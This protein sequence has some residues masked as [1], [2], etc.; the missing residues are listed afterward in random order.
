MDKKVTRIVAEDIHYTR[1]ELV[2]P[3]LAFAVVFMTN[4]PIEG[5]AHAVDPREQIYAITD[6]TIHRRDDNG[7][8][9]IYFDKCSM[10]DA[11]HWGDEKWFFD[12]ITPDTD[13]FE[14]RVFARME[15]YLNQ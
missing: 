3:D 15:A 4:I 1:F 12:N 5:V 7:S 9:C 10:Y 14:S 6:W 2:G 8:P 13:D 11:W